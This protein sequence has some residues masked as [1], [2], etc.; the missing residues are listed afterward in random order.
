MLVLQRQRV[1]QLGVHVGEQGGGHILRITH[2]TVHVTIGMTAVE[3]QAHEVLH[4]LVGSPTAIHPQ[5]QVR[6]V[7]RAVAGARFQR[8]AVPIRQLG[9]IVD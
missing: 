9:D 7:K 8:I 1:R 3:V 6:R 4:A 2:L 5:R